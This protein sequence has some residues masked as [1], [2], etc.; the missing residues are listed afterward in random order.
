M[1][2]QPDEEFEDEDLDSDEAFNSED[3]REYGW[4]FKGKAPS[5]G[6]SSKR[7]PLEDEQDEMDEIDQDDDDDGVYSVLDLINK[8]ESAK[9]AAAPSKRSTSGGASDSDD[10]GSDSDDEDPNLGNHEAL[11][12]HVERVA[13]DKKRKRNE[14]EDQD[15]SR[16]TSSSSSSD[17]TGELTADDLLS[18][19]RNSS[20]V[21]QLKKRVEKLEDGTAVTA[22][23]KARIHRKRAE[24]SL[25]YEH[26]KKDATDWTALVSKN[27]QAEHVEFAADGPSRT[28]VTTADMVDK[29]RPTTD[30]EHQIDALLTSS[31]MDES[32]LKDTENRDLAMNDLTE[33]EVRCLRFFLFVFHFLSPDDDKNHANS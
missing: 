16:Q 6:S 10:N 32:S 3:E 11:L 1:E 31:G 7:H 14:G 8:R 5:A 28:P 9:K 20:G 2:R 15:S 4:A 24:R 33:D 17:G 21:A 19:L 12:K 30:M 26:A 23:P 18:S 27:R 25:G 29:F 13:N 22:A